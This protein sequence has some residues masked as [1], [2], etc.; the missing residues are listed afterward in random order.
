MSFYLTGYKKNYFLKI[1]TIGHQ[2]LILEKHQ[3]LV[4]W[5]RMDR[6]TRE[7]RV[8]FGGKKKLSMQ[9]SVKF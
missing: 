5:K 9:I 3:Y 2:D 8:L 6:K 7:V 1:G 4:S